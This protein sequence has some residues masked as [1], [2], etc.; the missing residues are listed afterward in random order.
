MRAMEKSIAGI[1]KVP[2]LIVLAAVVVLAVLLPLQQGH[3]VVCADS[4]AASKETPRHGGL[5]DEDLE[6]GCAAPEEVEHE[7]T[8][9]EMGDQSCGCAAGQNR[10]SFSAPEG[11]QG[12]EIYDFHPEKQDH[13][14]MTIYDEL[15]AYITAKKFDPSKVKEMP[16]KYIP[17]GEFTMGTNDPQIL[18]DA[19]G[20]AR[21]VKLSAFYLDEME[22]SNRQFA[23]FVLETKY[24]TE[25]E[26]FGWSFCFHGTLSE[27]VLDSIDVQVA[28]VPWWIPTP[29]AN[30]MH[31][32]GPD[33]NII[34]DEMLDYPVVH[35]SHN[36]ARA[37][38]EWAGKRLP[39]EAEFERAA[40]G[41]LEG[42]LYPWG[43]EMV[44]NGTHRANLWQGH[45]PDT[46]TAEDGYVWSSPVDSFG[47]QNKFGLKNIIGNVW[48][49]VADAWSAR[50]RLTAPDGSI[51]T[52]FQVERAGHIDDPT[53]ERVKKG[54]SYMCH[55]SYCYRYRVDSRSHN[56]ADSSAQNLGF[57]CALDVE[58]PQLTQ[59]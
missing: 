10:G 8:E 22:V 27:A 46:N 7:N 30:W 57:R 39:R 40:K 53:V 45:F 24:I 2:P 5:Q 13:L 21:R 19:E 12:T 23:D 59:E 11:V 26:Q 20:P 52:D 9:I 18:E 29:G 36:D 32:N 38:C 47:P 6:G 33:R 1:R 35:V 56:T 55:I 37:Y 50:H 25:A 3:A 28:E 14:D 48:E 16:M 44:P 31:P 34:T 51:L 17:A 15:Q 4:A 42:V 49:W 54:G 43:E 41:D 58:N